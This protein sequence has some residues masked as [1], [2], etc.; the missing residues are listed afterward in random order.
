[1]NE[2][3]LAA[4]GKLVAMFGALMVVLGLSLWLMARWIPSGG[5]PGDILVRRP[6]MVLYV[7]ITTALLIS[8][9]L[10]LVLTLLAWLR[11]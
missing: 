11:R 2:L 6:G 9:L 5:L 7:P 3:P 8:L 10:T 1:M 4:I